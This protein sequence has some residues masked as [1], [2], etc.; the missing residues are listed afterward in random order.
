MTDSPP[1]KPWNG[2]A[3]RTWL[4]SRFESARADQISAERHGRE[5]QDDCDKSAAEEMICSAL[6]SKATTDD[7]TAFAADLKSLLEKESYIWRGVYDDRRFDRHVRTYIKKL[8]RMT[9][10]NTGFENLS[11]F[12]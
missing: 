9:K 2:A 6:K 10:T 3:V 7:Q 12:Q 1:Q 11:R 4:E 8:A 5:R